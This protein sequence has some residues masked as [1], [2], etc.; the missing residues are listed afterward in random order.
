MR[1]Q[2]IWTLALA[3][4]VAVG[5]STLALAAGEK[6]TVIRAGNLVLTLNG[7]VTPKALPKSKLAPITIHFSG[8]IA[9]VDGSQPPAL[10]NFSID[11]GRTGAIETKGVPVCSRAKIQATTTQAAERACSGAIVGRG[12]TEV[13]VAFPESTP[14]TAD[15]PLVIF[16]GGTKGGKTLILIHAYVAVP[17][18]T[19]IVETITVTKEHRG[20]YNLH[21]TGP[22][23]PIAGGSGSVTGFDLT[24]NRRGYLMASCLGGTFFAHVVA[25]FRDGTEVSGSLTRPCKEI[26]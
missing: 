6:P 26:G 25:A 24:I 14:F 8:R 16:N 1:K 3:T 13:K 19:A 7:G 5:V 12:S 20:P 18:P 21:T 2:M 4:A 10:S 17:A 15:G 23:A 22:I 9:T 11:T